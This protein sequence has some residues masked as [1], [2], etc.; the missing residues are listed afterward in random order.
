[1]WDVSVRVLTEKLA[2]D[3]DRPACERTPRGRNG[4]MPNHPRGCSKIAVGGD[5]WNQPISADAR[6]NEPAKNPTIRH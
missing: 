3:A 2:Q 6:I 1:V 5:D 4:S